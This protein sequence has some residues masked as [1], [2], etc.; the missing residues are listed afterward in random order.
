VRRICD[1]AHVIFTD[2]EP[3]EIRSW[4]SEQLDSGDSLFVVEFERWSSYGA[5]VDQ[6]WLLRRGH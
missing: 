1:G 5:S 2:A 3:A 6:R 4:I